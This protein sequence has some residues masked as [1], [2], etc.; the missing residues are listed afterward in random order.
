MC[1]QWNKSQYTQVDANIEWQISDN[2]SLLSTT[3]VSEFEISSV[4]DWQLMGMEFRPPASTP[5]SSTR[6]F[7]STSRSASASTSSPA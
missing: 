4:S 1:L 6:N 5:T 7:S 3:G 2:L